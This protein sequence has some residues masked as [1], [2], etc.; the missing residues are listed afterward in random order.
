MSKEEKI[1]YEK[2][3]DDK[4]KEIDSTM[5]LEG[6]PLTKDLKD[7]LKKCFYGIT[8]PQKEIDRLKDKYKQ[9]YG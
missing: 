6:M 7:T 8:T 1:K 9:I 4:I 5:A 2:E 3:I